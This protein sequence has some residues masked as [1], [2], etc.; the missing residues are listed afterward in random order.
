MWKDSIDKASIRELG[1]VGG[2]DCDAMA[3]RCMW[4][5]VDI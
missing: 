2:G 1:V 3:E 4:V 5:E